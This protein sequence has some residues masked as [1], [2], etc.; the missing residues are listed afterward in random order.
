M[1]E[2]MAAQVTQP[3]PPLRLTDSVSA[4]PGIGPQKT[5]TL[6]EM[7]LWTIGDILNYQGAQ[8]RGINVP[9]LK[10]LIEQRLKSQ[11]SPVVTAPASLSPH[12]DKHNWFGLCGHALLGRGKTV[13]VRIGELILAPYGC[14]LATS[15]RHKNDWKHRAI[16]PLMLAVAHLLWTRI[17]VV[18]DSDEEND[19]EALEYRAAPTDLPVFAVDDGQTWVLSETQRDQ[20][21]LACREVKTFQEQSVLTLFESIR[22]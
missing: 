9:Q 6:N 14:V 20:L 3:H 21:Q 7:G 12:T 15:W 2:K 11:P 17:D 13:R 22:E 8:P 16:S 4:L 10:T 19:D 18:S 5:K 1:K